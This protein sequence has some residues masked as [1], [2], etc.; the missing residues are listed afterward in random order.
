MVGEPRLLTKPTGSGWSTSFVARPPRPLPSRVLA[1]RS[2]VTNAPRLSGYYPLGYIITKKKKLQLKK[3]NK[4]Y[5]STKN[6]KT[7][8]S[9]QKLDY[10][11]IGFFFIKKQKGKL[12]YELDFPKKIKIYPVF[13]IFLL[14]PANP[15]ILIPIKPSKL[16]SEN[17]YKIEKIINYNYK[18]Q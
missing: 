8:R 1:A 2:P 18:N 15:E 7:I 17:K 12:N 13:Y 9:S 3:K 4:I 6:F 16:S 5:F 11:K 10:K 14:E